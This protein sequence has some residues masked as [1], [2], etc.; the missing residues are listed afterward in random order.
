MSPLS[1]VQNSMKNLLFTLALTTLIPIALFA[2]K[3]SVSVAADTYEMGSRKVRIPA[4]DGFTDATAQFPNVTARLRAT[5]DPGN[6]MLAFHIPES[7]VPKLKASEDIDLEF[8]TKISVPR[9]ARTV[10]ITQADF[11]AVTA[12][13]EKN[14]GAYIEPD[15]P[16]MTNVQK[17]SGKGLTEL[18]GKETSVSI[19]ETKYLGVIEKSDAVFSGMLLVSFEIYG[20]K[21]STLGTLSI[22]RVNQR[23]VFAYAYRLSPSGNSV[24]ELTQLTKKW[25]AKIVAAN[26]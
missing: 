26:K 16:L 21:L 19:N 23:L 2:Q 4:P 15:G 22:V 6:D 12:N 1:V 17:N 10:D 14:F 13:L 20:R 11:A 5:E 3:P 24:S 9:R 18:L 25:T 7:F 8:Y